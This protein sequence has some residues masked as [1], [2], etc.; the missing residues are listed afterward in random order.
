MLTRFASRYLWFSPFAFIVLIPLYHGVGFWAG[1][2][3]GVLHLALVAA[4]MH[5]NRAFIAKDDAGGLLLGPMLLVAGGA[6]VWATG[7][8]GPPNPAHP[9]VTLFN[10]AGLTLGFF[11]TLLGIAGTASTSVSNRARATAAVG[12]SSF[13]LMFVIWVLGSALG[14]AMS[15]SSLVAL[16]PAQRPEVFQILRQFRDLLLP[17]L[18][19]GGYWGGA[20]LSET[21]IRSGWVARRT[22]RLMFI[23]CLIGMFALPLSQ[24]LFFPGGASSSEVPRMAWVLAPWLPPAMFCLVPYHVGVAGLLQAARTAVGP[25]GRL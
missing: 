17:A 18:A 11:V 20:M 14:I 22:G 24:F 7:P 9:N 3:G 15:R 8:S 10:Q 12:L 5:A 16:A 21:S 13:S 2:T 25:G 4:G 1:V 6:E 19:V 23:Y